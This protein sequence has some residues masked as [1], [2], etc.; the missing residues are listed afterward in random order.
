MTF[1]KNLFKFIKKTQLWK[2]HFCN[3]CMK[4][5]IEWPIY[6]LSYAFPH[7]TWWQP[8][9]PTLWNGIDWL[10]ILLKN[11]LFSMTKNF[12]FNNFYFIGLKLVKWPPHTV[13][14]WGLFDKVQWKALRFKKVKVCS[15]TK[16][17]KTKYL[18]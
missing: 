3:S 18:F 2:N 9:G 17:N 1:E 11:Y 5:Q 10:K 15:Q 16:Q 12:K 8:K 4:R 13:P 6:E 7:V 14:C